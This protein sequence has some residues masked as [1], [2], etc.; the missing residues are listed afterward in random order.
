MDATGYMLWTNLIDGY[1]K[2]T[3][4]DWVHLPP[5]NQ[6]MGMVGLG[7]KEKQF[8]VCDYFLG[9]LELWN[10]CLWVIFLLQQ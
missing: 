2:L 6:E 4:P 8:R 1:G 5:T 9:H 10:I 3:A 7:H